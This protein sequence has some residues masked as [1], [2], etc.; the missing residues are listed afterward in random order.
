M[1]L[2]KTAIITGISGQDG[3]YLAELLLE[4]N[5][6]VIGLIRRSSMEDKKLYNIEHLLNN[7]NLTS[8]KLSKISNKTQSNFYNTMKK[9]E[10][11]GLIIIKDKNVLKFK[12]TSW[13][14]YK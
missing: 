4:K 10:K 8:Y 12:D 5:Y 1:S 2:V 11:L 14:V 3:S 7:Q 9:M 6:K 13:L